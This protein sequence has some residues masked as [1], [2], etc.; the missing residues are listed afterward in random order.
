MIQEGAG[1]VGLCACSRGR[2]ANVLPPILVS[3]EDKDE[4]S[5]VRE[6]VSKTE[7]YAF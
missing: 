7:R 1:L 6:L 4:I 5:F 2:L 3:W